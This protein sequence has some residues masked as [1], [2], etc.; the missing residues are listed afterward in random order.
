MGISALFSTQRQQNMAMSALGQSEG[1]HIK[2]LAFDNT[3]LQNIPGSDDQKISWL[4]L[5]HG[6]ANFSFQALKVPGLS[7]HTSENLIRIQFTFTHNVNPPL[8]CDDF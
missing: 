5:E 6:Q 4:T 7:D 3:S 1:V 2:C 8:P